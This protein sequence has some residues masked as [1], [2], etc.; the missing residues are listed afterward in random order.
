MKYKVIMEKGN[1]AVILRKEKMDEYAVVRGLNK[2][3]GDWDWTVQYWNF[4]EY[5]QATEA[6]CLMDALD[7][8]RC[9]TEDDY[10]SRAAIEEIATLSINGMIEDDEESAYEYIRENMDMNERKCEFFEIDWERAK[11]RW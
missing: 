3:K 5:T 4:S 9:K 1:Y 6:E 7:C 10:I 8:F 2:E 11:P